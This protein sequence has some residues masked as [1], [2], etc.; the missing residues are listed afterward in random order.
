MRQWKITAL[1]LA[2]I[3]FTGIQAIFGANVLVTNMDLTSNIDMKGAITTR[4]DFDLSFD[5]G[6]KYQGK[7]MLQYLNAD[8]E[9][10]TLP[11]LRFYGA[12]AS[13]KN[14]FQFLD[15]TYWTGYYGI[16]GKGKHYAGHLYHRNSGF[17]YNGY[18]PV[19]GTGL[20]F[21]TDYYEKYGAQFFI[22]QRYGG[23]TVNSIDLNFSLNAE[24]LYLKL[25]T[26]ASE[27][28]WRSAVQCQL[29]GEFT[30]LYLT[31]GDPSIE[32]GNTVTFDDFYFLLEEWFKMN[33]W[34]LILSV[35]SRPEVQYNYL[36]RDYLPTG[37][38]NDIDFNFDL[39][40]APETSF[41]SGGS[42][43]NIQT[44]SNESF[45]VYVSPYISIFTSG[46]IW[47]VKIDF[48]ILSENRDF[49]TAYLNI[50][51]SF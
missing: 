33:R 3:L 13:V 14:I 17:E 46:V 15:L 22:Y 23:S 25:F 32:S 28:A 44:N 9:G 6:Y 43:L 41:F 47:K 27:N 2:V 49:I 35:F 40:Y 39:N 50:Q 42:E 48:N 36:T 20:V 11:T 21:S 51:A 5:G 38:K 12:Q 34:N 37:E 24:P 31:A 16:L 1:L 29:L 45:G 18:F 8:I 19:Q 7:L 26:G 4:G 10:N 30:D